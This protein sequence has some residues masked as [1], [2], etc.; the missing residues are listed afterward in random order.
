MLD[1]N[2][3]RLF[4]HIVEHQGILRAGRALQLPKS[5]MS[6]RLA[7]LEEQLKARLVIRSGD[8]FRLTVAG[9][10]AYRLGLAMVEAAQHAEDRLMRSTDAISGR[11]SINVSPL[12]AS[13]LGLYIAAMTQAHPG[14]D[15]VVDVADRVLD[16]TSDTSDLYLYAHHWPLRDSPLIQRRICRN[17]LLLV[18]SPDVAA[19]VAG[20]PG[21]AS[22]DFPDVFVHGLDAGTASWSFQSEAGE[23]EILSCTPRLTTTNVEVLLSL[24]L[25]GA[26]LVLLPEF[27]VRKAVMEGLLVPVVPGWIGPTLTMTLLSPPRRLMNTTLR[28]VA[29]ELGAYVKTVIL[30]GNQPVPNPGRGVLKPGRVHFMELSSA[31]PSEGLRA[32]E[33]GV[34][35]LTLAESEIA[36]RPFLKAFGVAAM[37]VTTAISLPAAAEDAPGPLVLYTNDFEGV[38]TERFEA[39]T[40]RQID[41][42]Q[43]SGGE[44]LARIA[45]EAANPQ[46]DVLIFNGSY[47]FKMLDGQNQL[48]RGVEPA[49]IGNL[50]ETGRTYL[51]ENRSWFPIGMAASCV[52]LYRTDRIGNPPAKFSDLADSRFNGKFGMADPAIAAPAYP[53]VAEFFHSLGKDNAEAYFTSL[54]DNGMRVFRTNGPVGRA[55]VSGELDLAL[56][57]SQVAYSLKAAGEAPVEVVWPEEGAPGVVRGVGIQASTK[58][59]EAARTFVEWLLKPETQ[60]YLSQAAAADGLFEPTVEGVTRR[61]DGPAE[62]AVYRVAP[63]DF[64]VANE[65]EIKTWFADRALQ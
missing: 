24:A 57:T 64:S 38:I 11:V 56:I 47:S 42:V 7:A 61:A 9:E 21:P 1:L 29:D 17:P 8:E 26:G 51:P 12:L 40:G 45:A 14:L 32:D 46:W 58:R 60:T 53:C 2:D 50:N 43:M 13:S 23:A 54:F 25:S 52:M 15:L 35:T 59:S 27:A 62:G 22:L 19:C 4:V 44:I 39:D 34:A 20:A 55:I 33:S 3:L 28:R 65:A 41:V 16:Q 31:S 30:Q 36:M 5:T 18:A 63:D 37:T 48:L 10:E 6:R 49:N